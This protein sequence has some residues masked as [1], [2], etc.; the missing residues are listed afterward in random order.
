MEIFEEEGE[1]GSILISINEDLDPDFLLKIDWMVIIF[2]PKVTL[3]EG[4]MFFG[5]SDF[6]VLNEGYEGNSADEEV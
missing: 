3:F 5:E 2:S 4:T 6:S 1:Y